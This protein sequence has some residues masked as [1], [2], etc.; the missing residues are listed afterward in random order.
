MKKLTRS[1][2]ILLL[3]ALPALAQFEGVLD[4]K[5]TMVDSE[6]ATKGT[7]DVKMSI[8]KPGARTE[9]TMQAMQMSMKMVMLVKT[10]SPD[11]VYRI[12][13]EGKSY[14]EINVAKMRD[15][16]AEERQDTEK[17]R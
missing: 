8:A 4:M 16:A 1:C 12:N 7:G 6:G 17:Y 9:M 2:L 10:D 13:D 5:V 3:T 15:A 11:M 14:S